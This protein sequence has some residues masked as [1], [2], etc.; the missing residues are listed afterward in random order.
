MLWLLDSCAASA[1]AAAAFVGMAV[2]VRGAVDGVVVGFVL[3]D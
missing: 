3:L 1:A 2:I